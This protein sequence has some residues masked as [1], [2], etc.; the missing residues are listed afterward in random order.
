MPKTVLR[1]KSAKL[2]QQEKNAVL[3]I[4][5]DIDNI[6]HKIRELKNKIRELE[7]KRKKVITDKMPRVYEKTDRC[8]DVF[9]FIKEELRYGRKFEKH[10]MCETENIPDE[11]IMRYYDNSI[12][13]IENES[14]KLET[15]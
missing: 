7:H 1:G 4:K 8:Y 9:S 2:Y 3:S 5:N 13:F 15:E 12:F 10:V 14:E 11:V 6:N